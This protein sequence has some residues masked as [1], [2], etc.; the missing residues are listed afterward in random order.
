VRDKLSK[1]PANIWYKYLYHTGVEL[2]GDKLSKEPANIWYKYFFF[3]TNIYIIQVLN[4]CEI[5]SLKNPPQKL[6]IGLLR[7]PQVSKET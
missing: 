2:V 1:E 3:G 6:L 7:Y 5:N 4:W